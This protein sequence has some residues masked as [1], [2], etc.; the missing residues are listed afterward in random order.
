MNAVSFFVDAAVR[1]KKI[2]DTLEQI[3]EEMSEALKRFNL[4]RENQAIIDAEMKRRANVILIQFVKVCDSS[5]KVLKKQKTL[6]LT[7]T[8]F[9]D[10]GGV[11]NELDEL[12]K[13]TAYE[14]DARSTLAY[15]SGKKTEK[16]TTESHEILK[17]VAIS[18]KQ[19]LDKFEKQESKA[20]SERQ[21]ASLFKKLLTPDLN[22]H[23][24]KNRSSLTLPHLTPDAGLWVSRLEKFSQW[25]DPE[26]SE[27]RLLLLSGHEG[28]GKT[29]IVSKLISILEQRH[30]R[31][32]DGARKVLIAYFYCGAMESRPT[33]A[34]ADRSKTSGPSLD[35][36]LRTL[37]MQIASSEEV[38]R[39][40]LKNYLTED[41]SLSLNVDELWETLFV[42]SAPGADLFLFLDDAHELEKELLPRLF[43]I[44]LK[45][46]AKTSSRIQLL[47]S[48]RSESLGQLIAT[49]SSSYD[50]INVSADNPDIAAYVDSRVDK[51]SILS[52]KNEQ[53]VS[54]RQS[55]RDTLSKLRSFRDVEGFLD[56][57]SKAQRP[58]DIQDL[59]QTAKSGVNSVLD[60][61]EKCNALPQE[62][63]QDLN[64]LLEWTI[65][66]I[67]DPTLTQLEAVLHT[68]RARQATS[69]FRPLRERIQS[70]FTGLFSLIG[71][72]DDRNPRVQIGSEILE[73]HFRKLTEEN[74]G[75]SQQLSE[76]PITELEVKIVRRFLRNLC[77]EELYTKF[78]FEDFFQNKLSKTDKVHVNTDE[79]NGNVML[80]CLR[81]ILQE[82][83]ADV[84]KPLRSYTDFYWLDHLIKMDLSL[85]SQNLKGEVGKRLAQMFVDEGVLGRWEKGY[86][87]GFFWCMNEEHTKKLLRWV[88]DLG[89]NRHC[90][91]LYKDWVDK[92]CSPPSTA[93]AAEEL[94]RPMMRL[95]AKRWLLGFRI[96]D[97]LEDEGDDDREATNSFGCV[98]AFHKMVSEVIYLA[99]WQLIV[100][101]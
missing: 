66:A 42:R 76:M 36:A 79:M 60:R 78:E 63:V 48:A 71:R 16:I 18:E 30:L 91:S 44:F 24:E 3:F 84:T 31:P 70:E 65:T 4:Y 90:P 8:L 14:A 97:D 13:M 35:F 64:Q 10:D 32:K 57:I 101:R 43:E 29:V 72:E 5:Y 34:R 12:K 22:M 62:D 89:V 83:D 33:D 92:V 100:L 45:S 81:V 98:R 37:A 28:G 87:L 56:Q 68:R 88:Q 52:G 15:I 1:Y 94:W 86:E 74:H 50:T 38:Y 41:S 26:D 51:I 23:K 96:M 27:R 46:S 75:D 53:L 59:L 19:V 9:K 47:V 93:S 40:S 58:K 11:S 25:A 61:L 54:L 95:E 85:A 7:S 2:F 99:I 17:T 6:W 77:D 39:N 80:D 20:E 55:S 21:L 73:E 67:D 49:N 82:T 69:S